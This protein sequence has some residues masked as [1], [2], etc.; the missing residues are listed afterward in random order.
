M[1][2]PCSSCAKCCK[3]EVELV[4]CVDEFVPEE[5]T[6]WRGQY[7]FMKQQ[8]GACVA[9]KNNLCGIYEKRPLVC[10]Q[11]NRGGEECLKLL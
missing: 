1:N 10:R 2:T 6:E 3:L 5:M 9:L 7:R 8:N 4:E 11:F